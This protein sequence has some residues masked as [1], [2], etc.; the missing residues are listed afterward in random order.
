[1]RAG[2][3]RCCL[4]NISKRMIGTLLME[5]EIKKIWY[6]YIM[7]YFSATKN[8][9]LSFAGKC[10]KL[11]DTMLSTIIQNRKTSIMCFLLHVSTKSNNEILMRS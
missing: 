4:V 7:E 5:K 6:V 2:K 10:M 9:A 1:M 8:E 11:Q 3:E